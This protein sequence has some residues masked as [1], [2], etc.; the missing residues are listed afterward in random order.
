MIKVDLIT[1]FLG[2]GKTTFLKKYADY[3]IRQG[4]KIG[5]LENDFGAVN[6][7][8]MLLQ[9]LSGD[10]C[11][12]ETV[13]GACDA[14]CHKRRFKTKLIALGMRGFDR[15]LIEPSGIFDVDEF[16]DV[17]HEEPLE[18][19]YESGSV[20]AIVDA[21]LESSLSE[22]SEFLLASQ[23]ANAG[24]I[25]LSKVQQSNTADISSTVAHIN[26][27]LE[28]FCCKRRLSESEL[29]IKNWES[30]TD[31]D[32]KSISESGYVSENYVKALTEDNG[33]S[34][35][36]YMNVSISVSKLCENIK[37][38]FNS[39]RGVFRIK[40]FIYENESWFEINAT[41]QNTEIKPIENGQEIIIVIGENMNKDEIDVYF[42]D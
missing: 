13:A 17:L 36:Y 4:N 22:Q 16:F 27:S 6:V 12:L 42:K 14:D 41:R 21:N 11:R 24:K 3:L 23:T 34:S 9:E 40:G 28:H 26:R 20:I 1:G 7:D 38:I 35:Y 10:N 32:F 37:H 19:W 39:C 8:M 31:D 2:S 33:Y 29:L 15:V 30:L 18:S 25:I 5:I